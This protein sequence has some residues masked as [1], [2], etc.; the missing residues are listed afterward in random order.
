MRA[1]VQLLALL[2]LASWLA[3]PSR[4]QCVT[5]DFDNL[6]V[7]TV[8]NNQYAGVTISG[9]DT[10]GTAGVSPRIYNPNGSTTSEPQC[11]SAWGDGQGE[12]SNEFLRFDFHQTQ[13]E[14]TFNLG[15]RTGCLA[16]DTVQVRWYENAGG[17]QLR[18][19]NNVPV[20]GTLP[21]ERVLVFVRVARAAGFDRI[22][23]EAGAGGICASRFELI[24]DLSFDSDTTPPVAEIDD[25]APLAC[26]CNSSP[27]SGSAYDPDGGIA[28]WR[29]ERKAPDA[30]S[31]T[32]IALS[33]T[34]R[35]DQQLAV[36][37]TA[38]PEGWYI[39]R[40]TVTNQCGL[41]DSATTVVWLDKAFNALSL[42]AP[43]PGAVLGGVVCFDGTVTDHCGG[44]FTIEHRPAG[45][46]GFAE[47]DD[48]NPPWITNDP[49]GSW[50]TRV[51][52]VDGAHE[53]RVLAADDCG[54]ALASPIV[55]LVI[56][57]TPPVAFIT[58]PAACASVAGVV[59]VRGTVADANL[60]GWTLQ[61]TGGGQHGWANIA[62]GAGAVANGVLGW[63]DTRQLDPCCY[64]LRLIAT[65]QAVLDCNPGARHQ[66][67][68]NVS[69][70]V[71]SGGDCPED[72]DGDGIVTLADLALLLTAFGLACP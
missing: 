23:V 59:D 34:E 69:V 39:L 51:G 16:S 32:L 17:Y 44:D 63:W 56:D 3:R 27:V 20:N 14:V 28:S 35:I 4:G 18:G 58:F 61:Y 71:G 49:L 66:T 22:E 64:T 29:L 70:D 9:R 7:G 2:S 15:V 13:T 12:F 41:T 48:V 60:A 52:A 72:I 37:T 36:W 40:L 47:V 62:Q 67:E 46:G 1:Q 50:D 31:W 24:D 68:F 33:S 65:D 8:V 43:A 19:F 5:I 30:D 45:G 11:L 21:T 26:V 38:A 25:P 54:N 57:N 10:D 6:A 53:V 55:P 42:R